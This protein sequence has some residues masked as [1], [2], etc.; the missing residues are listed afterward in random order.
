VEHLRIL[1]S[2]LA[3]TF[4]VL[5]TD[6]I[7][8]DGNS[9]LSPAKPLHIDVKADLVAMG[10]CAANAVG[11]GKADDTQAIQSAIDHAAKSGG[12]AVVLAPGVYRVKDIVLPDKVSLVGAGQDRT[13]LRAADDCDWL[14]RMTGGELTGLT[15]YG[16]PSEETSGDNWVP[17]TKGIGE[18]GSSR[19]QHILRVSGAMNGVIISNVKVLESRYDCLYVRGS[20]G[21]RVLNCTFDR[22]GRNI[23]SMVGNDED[24]VFSN[25]TIGS[26]WG[27]YHF[28]IEPGDDRYVRDGVIA[29]CTFDGSKAGEKG[30]DTW[31][32]F[33]C[34]SGHSKLESR[35]IVI[36]GCK[37]EKIYVR[38][39][40]VFPNVSF[41]YNEVNH[42]PAFV[43]VHTNK[44]G[45]LRDAVVRGNAFWKEARKP[46]DIVYGVAFTGSSVFADNSPEIANQCVTG[47]NGKAKE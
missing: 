43:R 4:F 25:C 36:T 8:A 6:L 9:G 20:K 46:S 7:S 37:F 41:L 35:N 21:L 29:N 23:V 39:R 28:D 2:V 18:G 34:L 11:D 13:I 14:V 47:R 32:S 26:L 44:V 22:A 17:G 5:T 15:L 3:L 16:T 38:V 45:E 31:G 24:F 30:T 42:K 40:G 12:G 1:W 19:T 33:L 10:I 27:L